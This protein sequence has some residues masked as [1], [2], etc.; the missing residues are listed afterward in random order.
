MN[1]KGISPLIAA[2]LLIAFTV[3]I[4]TV[5]MGWMSTTTRTTTGTITTQTETVVDCSDASVQIKHVYS[6][7]AAT[8]GI[9][10]CNTGFKTL[11]VDGVIYSTAGATCDGTAVNISAGAC[12]KVVAASCT[13]TSGTFDRA[14]ISTNCGGVGDT[15]T[16]TTY[17][18]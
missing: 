8:D 18:N 6:S 12:D 4:A 3:A 2:V 1:N 13:I 15:M 7:N 5:I 17:F 10:V 14:V 16:G 9:F 11:E